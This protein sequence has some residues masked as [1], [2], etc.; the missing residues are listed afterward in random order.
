M[1]GEDGVNLRIDHS[2]EIASHISALF[3]TK[4]YSDITLVVGS[5]QFPV[6]RVILASRCEYFRAL[7]FGGLSETHAST[8]HLNGINST[9]FYHVLSYIYTGRLKIAGLQVSLRLCVSL[10][11][12]NCWPSCILF[13]I[14]LR[15][16]W[17]SSAWSAST[18]SQTCR[19]LF[20]H[21]LCVL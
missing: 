21:I 4:D 2:S 9:A 10:L 16:H 19:M 7:F 20:P 11:P 8:V 3:N 17:K 6:H 15:T 18:T 12:P 13:L 14:R 1:A 5:S